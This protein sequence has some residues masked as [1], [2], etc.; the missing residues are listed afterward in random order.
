MQT[1]TDHQNDDKVEQLQSAVQVNSQKCS[2]NEG[3]NNG[4]QKMCPDHFPNSRVVLFMLIHA[5]DIFYK[6]SEKN[7]TKNLSLAGQID[8]TLRNSY[9]PAAKPF[10]RS[11]C[12]KWHPYQKIQR[13]AINLGVYPTGHILF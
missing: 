7:R 6:F 9:W 13:E 8:H 3:C 5:S 4:T 12:K 10:F 11:Q 2:Q 1:N